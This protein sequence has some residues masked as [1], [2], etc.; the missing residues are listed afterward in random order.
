MAGHV[1]YVQRGL[2]QLLKVEGIALGQTQSNMQ[3]RACADAASS[4]FLLSTNSD[5]QRRQL[6]KRQ[7][8]LRNTYALLFQL[9]SSGSKRG[10][11]QHPLGSHWI[12]TTLCG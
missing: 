11:R 12:Y 5:V 7:G 1:I 3:F 8:N 9:E 4:L 2:V 10:R 6:F